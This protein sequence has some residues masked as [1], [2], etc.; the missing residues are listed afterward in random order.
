MQAKKDKRMKILRI[1]IGGYTNIQKSE[2][3]LNDLTALIAPNNY[4]K[5]NVL[6]AISF[7]RNFIVG[8]PEIKSAMMRQRSFISIN[9]AIADAPFSFEMECSTNL[10]NQNVSFVYGFSFDWAKTEGNY[11]GANITE[12]HLRVKNDNEKRYSS[13]INRTS[14]SSA[15][16][17]QTPKGRCDKTLQLMPNLLAVN[18]LVGYDDLFFL[19]ILK[20]IN[21]VNIK[22]VNTLIDPDNFF[23]LSP[24]NNIVS[25]YS[26]DFTDN[27][28]AGF[29]IY[30]MKQLI[31]EKYEL[32]K[33]VILNLMD[34]VVDFEPVQVNIQKDNEMEANV[35][36]RSSD[37]LYDIRVKERF[38]NQYTSIARVSSGTKR[39]IFVLTLSLVAS[40]NNIPLITFE[41][42]ENSVHPRLLE[43]LI[44][45]IQQLSGD[46]KVLITS[47]SP[48]LVKYLQADDILLGLPNASG[49][50][51]FRKLKDN[52]IKKAVRLASAE[53]I[54][55][56]EFLF[57]LMLDGEENNDLLNE[58]FK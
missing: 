5:S 52:K 47:H 22:S 57:E 44:E 9:T 33:D 1:S 20:E 19:N 36:F 49:L 34:D 3:V 10:Q 27:T 14:S 43:N 29:L 45:A 39:I 30:S 40:I 35:P 26:V 2:I 21:S 28:N 38:N 41:E 15:K 55:L 24:L 58:L 48:Y 13:Y 8:S 16:Y 18:K 31:P 25:D 17:Q 51:E 7:A 23:A 53:E 46:C 50:A 42:L 32:L 6:S 54:T 12:E 11:K 4:G 56:G 37:V